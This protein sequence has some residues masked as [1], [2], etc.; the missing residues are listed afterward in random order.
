MPENSP[1]TVE[2]WH[3]P[4]VGAETKRSAAPEECTQPMASV[5]RRNVGAM[6]QE[7]ETRADHAGWQQK[8]AE[9]ITRFA[10]SMRFVYLHLA[11]FG[12]WIFGNLGVLPQVQP[13][14]PSFVMLGMIASVE[15]IFLSTF[16]LISQNAM[17]A[18]AD[19]RA[20]LDL[21]VNLLA[22]HEVTKLVGLMSAVA[23]KLGVEAPA[24]TELEEA[25]QDVK[26][27]MVLRQIEHPPKL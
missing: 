25:K 4:I 18:A 11:G 10:G 23:D 22:E 6:A 9:T 21:Q 26:P 12:L 1:K 19:R 24:A 13:W 3:M 14:D 17:S 8:V 7:A 16:I 5:L 20:E 27:E 2:D 15:A